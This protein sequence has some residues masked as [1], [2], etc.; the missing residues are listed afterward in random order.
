MDELFYYTE[1]KTKYQALIDSY[2][3]IIKTYN[4]IIV[5]NESFL[6][7][8][9]QK[10]TSISYIGNVKDNILFQHII[11]DYLRTING[12]ESY[13]IVLDAKIDELTEL[14]NE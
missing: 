3:S 1:M 10:T 2:R 9:I 14:I 8:K 13:L 12:L 11:A 6:N 5:D 4:D 7:L